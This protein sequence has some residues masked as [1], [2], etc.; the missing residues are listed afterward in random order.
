MVRKSSVSSASRRHRRRRL[1][2]EDWVEAAL[3]RL[4]TGG[5]ETVRVELLARDLGVSKGSFYWHFKDRAELLDAVLRRW[6]ATTERVIASAAEA[7]TPPERMA[8]FLDLATAW[9]GD[10]GEA[11]LENAVLAWAQQDP[12]VAERVAA[13]EAIR[14]KNAEQLL[15]ELGFPPAEAAAWADLGY[16]TVVGLMSRSSRDPRFRQWP[17]AGYLARLVEAAQ[18]VVER[19]ATKTQSPRTRSRRRKRAKS[20]GPLADMKPTLRR[21]P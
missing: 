4:A 10:A 19:D 11:E 6:E 1:Q 13:V 5:V 9:A 14:T 8:R 12:A 17:Q 15:S 2:R 18:L 3:R 21:H 20:A 16:T 7:A